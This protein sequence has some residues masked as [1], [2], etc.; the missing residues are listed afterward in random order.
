MIFFCNEGLICTCF[1]TLCYTICDVDIRILLNIILSR[2]NCYKQVINTERMFVFRPVHKILSNLYT[3]KCVYIWR[4]QNNNNYAGANP[5][6][7][8]R[9]VPYTGLKGCVSIHY[10]LFKFIDRQKRGCS[11]PRNPPIWI[12][13]SIVI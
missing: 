12:R 11:Y 5:A 10:V 2:P 7:S 6:I 8:K 13:H 1:L 4:A 9:R 3:G